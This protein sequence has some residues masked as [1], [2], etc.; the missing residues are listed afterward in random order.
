MGEQQ[1]WTLL[2]SSGYAKQ[3]TAAV[4][5]KHTAPHTE[6]HTRDHR[7]EATSPLS[8]EDDSGK[9]KA[10]WTRCDKRLLKEIKKLERNKK[11][12]IK[13]CMPTATER[14]GEKTRKMPS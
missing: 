12:N 6:V 5:G 1:I 14:T 9:P 11:A 13:S 2:G 8:S 7:D 4:H 3:H 10:K